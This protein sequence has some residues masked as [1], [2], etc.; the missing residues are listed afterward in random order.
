MAKVKASKSKPKSLRKVAIAGMIGN[1]LEWYDY[2]LYGNFAPIIS[3]LFFPSENKFISLLVTYG[4][5]AAGFI[6]R[7]LGAII[8]GYIGDKYGRKVSL[9]ISILLM[10][11]PTSFIGLLPTYAQIGILAPILLTVIRLLQGIALGGEF[12]GS[13]TY[14]VEHSSPRNRNFAGSLSVVSLIAGMLL[15]SAVAALFA[16]LMD[17]PSLESWGWRI[18]FI[19]GFFIGIIGLYIRSF[20][21]ESPEYENAKEFNQLSTRP[22]RELFSKNFSGIAVACGLY[23]AVTA[24]FYMLSVFLNTFLS[25][26]AGFT[27]SQALTINTIG[28]LVMFALVPVSAK[29]SDR[30]GNKSVMLISVIVL[31]IIT[32]PF[33]W[34]LTQHVFELA[35]IGEI[36]FAA[37]LAFYIAPIPTALVDIFPT[38]VRYTGMAVACNL[39]AACFGG[40][41]PYI[42]TKLLQETGNNLSLAYYIIMTT[43]ISLGSLFFYKQK[44]L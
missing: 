42:A 18:P 31:G 13:I 14:I 37:V 23:I 7:P 40:T 10:A 41:T 21:S 15:G 39:C 17:K 44:K 30:Y 11:I 25:K 2:A 29:L 36:F 1:G 34:M 19:L 24:P 3:Q 33:F 8:F 16:N 43:I 22:I 12:S 32:L 5:F 38:K 27:L 6:M 20:L 4:V 28:M 9:A 35:I 26:F